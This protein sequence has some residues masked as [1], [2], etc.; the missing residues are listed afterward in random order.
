[1]IL[2]DTD[3]EARLKQG[4]LLIEPLVDPDLQIQPASVDLRLGGDFIVFRSGRT[5]C[6]YIDHPGDAETYTQDLHIPEGEHFILHPGEF[7][8]GTTLE[9]VR[10]PPDLVGRLEGRSSLGRLAVIVHATAGFIDPGFHGKITLELTNLGKVPVGLKPG[11]RCSQIVFH[12]LKTPAARPYG[13]E[14]GSKYQGQDGPIASR[15]NV[16]RQLAEQ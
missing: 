12:E 6:I 1:M 15:I 10:I 7:A 3:I 5:P 8:L 14:R 4:D 11:M 16:D 13:Q 9:T 2:S